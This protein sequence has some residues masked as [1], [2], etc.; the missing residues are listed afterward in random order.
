M[1]HRFH[2]P[3]KTL[4]TLAL[5]SGGLFMGGCPFDCQNGN[6]AGGSTDCVLCD[7]AHLGP[8]GPGNAGDCA[9]CCEDRIPFGEPS[10]RL[11]KD[12]CR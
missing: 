9:D 11:C 4:A 12:R 6:E 1:T 7:A 5:L 2:H 3:V 10:R 8:L